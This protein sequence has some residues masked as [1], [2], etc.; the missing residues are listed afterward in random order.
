MSAE[1]Q[2]ALE[3]LDAAWMLTNYLSEV[4]PNSEL[5]IELYTDSKS[6]YDC[7]RT[8]NLLTDKRLRVD[9]A[10]IREMVESGEVIVC[11]VEGRK[12]LADILTKSGLSKQN[13]LEILTKCRLA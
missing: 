1:T 12:H 9:V 4:L 6:L 11:W 8:T 5:K 3:A 7:V 2:A 13:L 10:A